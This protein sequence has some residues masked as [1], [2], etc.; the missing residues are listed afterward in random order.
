MGVLIG[1][2]LP[3]GDAA[4]VRSWDGS[5]VYRHEGLV[6]VVVLVCLARIVFVGGVKRPR[7]VVAIAIFA[8]DDENVVHLARHQPTLPGVPTGTCTP[9]QLHGVQVRH[10]TSAHCCWALRGGAHGGVAGPPHTAGSADAAPT[11]TQAPA[12]IEAATAPTSS[13]RFNMSSLSLVLRVL[14]R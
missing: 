13:N 3:F 7:N 14:Q 6:G 9:T 4:N 1:P 12:L 5:L 10:A 2:Q 8:D 11:P